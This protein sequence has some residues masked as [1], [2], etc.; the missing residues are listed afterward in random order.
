MEALE[1][2]AQ[3]EAQKAYVLARSEKWIIPRNPVV[4][5]LLSLNVFGEELWS[6]WIPE[7]LLRIFFY[8]DLA[9]IAPPK[10]SGKGLFTETPMVNDK[11]LDTVRSGKVCSK[12]M[13]STGFH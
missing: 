8:R 1:F 10:G 6:S 13:S 3:G 4:D 5:I 9:D 12:Q 11:V 7:T 2:V